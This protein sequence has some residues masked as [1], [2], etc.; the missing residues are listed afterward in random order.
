MSYHTQWA[1]PRM[2][3]TSCSQFFLIGSRL[4]EKTYNEVEMSYIKQGEEALKKSM[5][6]L[7]EQDG[8]KVEIV[9]V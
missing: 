9:A 7:G 4:D 2:E 8:W 1:N 5:S 3:D 6:I